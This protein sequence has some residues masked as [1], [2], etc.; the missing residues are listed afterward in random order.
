MDLVQVRYAARGPHTRQNV[1]APNE[2]TVNFVGSRIRTRRIRVRGH[3]ALVADVRNRLHPVGVDTG[4]GLTVS[5]RVILLKLF[6]NL[7]PAN[8]HALARVRLDPCL[9]RLLF[10]DGSQDRLAK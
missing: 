2:R 10:F 6:V 7:E 3:G 1:F 9:Y 4:Y 8:A 5:L